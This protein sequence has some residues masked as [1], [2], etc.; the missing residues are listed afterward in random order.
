MVFHVEHGQ[1]VGLCTLKGLHHLRHRCTIAQH[2]SGLHHQLL[3]LEVVVQLCAEHH[4]AYLPDVYLPQQ[5]SCRIGHRQ[6]IG[7]RTTDLM[8]HLSQFHIRVYPLV[9]AVDDRV[10][11]HQCQHRMVGMVGHQTSLL[12]Q[13]HTIDAVRFKDVD[14]EIGRHRDNHQRHEE[15]VATGNL[16]DEEDTRQWGV[17]HTR[18]HS[19]HSQQG[20]VLLRH[21]DTYL[22]HIPQT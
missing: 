5:R 9:V 2:R 8:N 13:T 21:V 7:M 22:V 3:R 15:I 12:G 1:P 16:S 18:H 14:G 4:M 10:Q 20:K 6:H 17:H 11:T 19:R